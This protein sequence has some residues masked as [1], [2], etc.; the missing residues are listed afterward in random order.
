MIQYVYKYKHIS[1]NTHFMSA[2]TLCRDKAGDMTSNCGSPA[3]QSLKRLPSA[4]S[5]IPNQKHMSESGHN[6]SYFIYAASYIKCIRE[7]HSF[8]LVIPT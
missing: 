5:I 7:M 6:S 1:E 4:Y 3:T 8:T 2:T